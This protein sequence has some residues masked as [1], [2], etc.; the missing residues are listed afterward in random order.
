MVTSGNMTSMRG[1]SQPVFV[2]DLTREQADEYAFKAIASTGLGS[3]NASLQDLYRGNERFGIRYAVPSREHVGMTFI[4]RP[5]LCLNDDILRQTSI[6]SPLLTED[7]RS[8]TAAVRGM[9]DPYYA[10]D[11]AAEFMEKNPFL[12]PHNP[13][14]TPI[15]NTMVG[16]TGW[17]DKTIETHTVHDGFFGENI[18]VVRGC[19]RMAKS[20]TLTMNIEDGFGSPSAALFQTWVEYMNRL[21]RG[22]ANPHEVDINQRLMC[23]TSSIY[24]YLF[25]PSGRFITRFA[26]AT[27]CYPNTD[28]MGPSFNWNVGETI[29]K[30]AN[31]FSIPWTVNFVEYNDSSIIKSFNR[32]VSIFNPGIENDSLYE[33]VAAYEL[34]SNRDGIPLIY[35]DVRTGQFVMKFRRRKGSQTVL[36]NSAYW[37]KTSSNKAG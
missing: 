36:G 9:M 25:D 14:I 24:R 7:M 6:L 18:T 12:V 19:D 8:H 1:T 4:T 30:G 2:P 37:G 11:N 35:S 29:I 20:Y 3:Y 26:K 15:C 28:A 10:F 32:L 22:E 13:F 31:Q 21:S 23:Y 5:A 16:L 17:P 27:G 34:A 33:D